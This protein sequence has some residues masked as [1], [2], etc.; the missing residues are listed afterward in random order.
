MVDVGGA[1][2]STLGG[3][4]SLAASKQGASGVVI[5]GGCRDIDEIRATKLWLA[6]RWVVPTTGKR[7]LKLQPLG[8]T[9]SVGGIEVS[10]GDLVVGDETGIVVV[11]RAK[12][13][14]VL[15]QAERIVAVDER[16]E[17]AI[18]AGESFGSAAAAAGY[19]PAPE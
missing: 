9:V 16:V 7:R 13:L 6:S 17:A 19:L 3:L 18:R 14:E 12:L 10:Q 15:E 1:P 4:A 5:D 8:G 2:V 11:P